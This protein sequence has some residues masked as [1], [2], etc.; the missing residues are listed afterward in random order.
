M[1][2][3]K[4]ILDQALLI[5]N[6]STAA[7]RFGLA[8]LAVI[9]VGA[10]VGVGIWSARPN[11]IDL[12]RNLDPAKA[13]RLIDALDGEDIAYQV[14]GSGSIIKVDESDLPRA[15]IAA[16]KLGIGVVDAELETVSP[17]MDPVSQ[18]ETF[19][20][21]LERQLESSLQ[22]L[23]GIER[24]DVHLS[25]PEKQAFIRER[26]SPSA[27][28]ILEI[29]PNAS[30]GESQAASIASTVANAVDGLSVEHVS[31][32]DTNGNTFATDE[33]LGRL[34]KQEEFRVMREKMLAR[35]AESMLSKFLGQGNV[36]VAVTADF[37][38]TE[39]TSTRI[40]FDPEM[41]V[42]TK[43][44]ITNKTTANDT[45]APYGVAGTASNNVPDQ[46]GN[47]KRATVEKSEQQT[48]E[49]EISKTERV[50]NIT[51]PTMNMMTVSVLVNS[52]SVADENGV[53]QPGTK[54]KVEALVSQAVGFRE[55]KDQITV[56][57]FEFV[58]PLPSE[59]PLGYAI[60]WDKLNQV[61][62]NLSLGLAAL[63][64]LFIAIKAMRKLNPDPTTVIQSAERNQQVSE[65]SEL[66]KQNPEVF[67][68]I[69][70]SWSS[71]EPEP[72]ERRQSKAA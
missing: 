19:R 64:A 16:G 55:G 49:Y 13:S 57:F 65:L 12:A 23:R 11:Y 72:E 41:K 26:N 40:E 6:D 63:V 60:P 47:S 53:P 68:K 21:N 9:C 39:G 27:A 58:D 71:I 33:S 25:I 59:E 43:E 54:E 50:E 10:I 14:R 61:I 62:K 36:S 70:E 4:S 1:Q 67:S 66:V 28:V 29:S 44:Q 24:A 30:F 56:E 5:W 7:A 37:S 46:G 42:V 69:I 2:T 51:T 3:L 48:N 38:F 18:Q 15:S 34:N 35:K 8:L 17:W 22:R 20:R 52:K 31:I 45:A 32:T